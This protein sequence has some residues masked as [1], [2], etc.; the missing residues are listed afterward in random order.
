MKDTK[1][2]NY[3]LITVIFLVI[4]ILLSGKLYSKGHKGTVEGIIINS[5]NNKPLESTTIY[6]KQDITIGT[7][8][9]KNGFFRL[10][11][12]TG[13]HTLIVSFTGMLR[14]KI[15]LYVRA[16]ETQ[17]LR[18][19]ME[20][21]AARYKEITVSASRFERKPEELLV[22][23]EIVK[24]KILLDKNITSID[25]GL[26]LVQGMV[27][28]DEDPQIRGGSGFT[29][30]VGSKV[31]VLLD[32][33]PIITG[34][35]GKPDWDLI[36]VENIKQMEVVKGPGSVLSGPNAM[37]GSV[38][39]YTQYPIDKPKTRITVYTGAN[40]TPADKTMKWWNGWN[41][42]AGLSFLHSQRFGKDSLNDI[43]VS[44]LV[45]FNRSYLGAPLQTI[46]SID[47][48]LVGDDEMPN[49]KIRLNV[50]YKRRTSAMKGLSYGI[51]GSLLFNKN[52]LVMAWYDDSTD[53]YRGYPG[54][55]FLRNQTAFYLDP[56]LDI[57]N[58]AGSKH[59]IAARILYHNTEVKDK[60]IQSTR[61]T[62][63]Y[64]LYEFTKT[65]QDLGNLDL[66]AGIYGMST[67]SHSLLYVA[68]GSPDNNVKDIAVYADANKKFG[69]S[70]NANFGLRG[71]YYSINDSTTYFKP[72]IRM[73]INFKMF[74]ETYLRFSYGQGYRFPSIAEKYISS[75]FGA[76]GVFP[77]LELKPEEGWNTE[78]GLK[79]GIKVFS[80]YGYL[81]IS[82]FYQ[83]YN[84]TVEY[85]FGFWSPDYKPAIAGFKFVNTG[86]SQ[87]SGLEFNLTAQSKF[88]KNSYINAMAGYTYVLPVSL[89][90]DYVF[91]KDYNPG[92]NGDFSYLSTS[93]NPERNILKYRFLHTVKLYFSYTYDFITA[94][95]TG[96]LFS[97]VINVD[98]AIFDFEETTKNIGGDFPPILYRDY[99][100]KN[101]NTRMVFDFNLSFDIGKYH[102]LSLIVNNFL[103]T[104]Y[105]LRPLKA[106]SM[107]QAMLQYQYNY[108]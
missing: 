50:N 43:V 32:N 59:H 3:R 61:A 27:M 16:G 9:D 85:L 104:I 88:D 47:S 17:K 72:F 87:I 39:L 94:G 42:I 69:S 82:A 52:S 66:V 35:A 75:S 86:R 73:G 60:P 48:V 84:N 21:F 58:L 95:I 51:N 80:F 46:P 28:L 53:F 6:T 100:Y 57:I 56:Y 70:V 77:N 97:K 63:I 26:E 19:V 93:V 107:R 76:F 33:I 2:N 74:Q 37:S 79:Q 45:D 78:I 91:A 7:Y 15:P 49:R 89:E 55:V 102:K 41:Y 106:E 12:D 108:N 11:L 18:I 105:S 20:P 99:F 101:N 90:P 96:R 65:Y 81:D 5:E 25:K 4:L 14:Q 10:K 92:G 103:N 40:D 13:K 36:P 24:P 8:S 31:N 83:H 38:F 23:T 1:S 68:S 71:E 22:S 29:F 54:T 44:G 62:T 34:E 64:G 67:M 30:G 98:K